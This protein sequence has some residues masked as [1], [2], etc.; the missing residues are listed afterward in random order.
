MEALSKELKQAKEQA[1]EI[2]QALRRQLIEAKQQVRNEC[3]M[4]DINVMCV[5]AIMQAA[6]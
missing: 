6:C 1:S 2:D 3:D 4:C 5:G